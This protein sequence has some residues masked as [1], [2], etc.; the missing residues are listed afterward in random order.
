M[1]FCDFDRPRALVCAGM[2]KVSVR[3]L[4]HVAFSSCG[5]AGAGADAG[6]G[7]AG[8]ALGLTRLQTV[9]AVTVTERIRTASSAATGAKSL[10]PPYSCRCRLLLPYRISYFPISLS[11]RSC[12]CSAL[13]CQYDIDTKPAAPSASSQPAHAHTHSR[14]PPPRCTQ[15]PPFCKDIQSTR[16]ASRNPPRWATCSTPLPSSSSPSAPVRTHT[17]THTHTPVPWSHRIGCSPDIQSS[18]LTLPPQHSTSPAPAGSTCCRASPLG[19]STRACP[20]RSA[21][22]SRPACTRPTL[23]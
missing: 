3:W 16:A 21:R 13:C 14:R 1:A 7:G 18:L 10:L 9:T 11:L 5:G 17:H 19:P 20:P 8:A 2:E 15:S 23:T 4:V 12:S 22:T 6:V